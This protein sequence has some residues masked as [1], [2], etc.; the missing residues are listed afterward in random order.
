MSR[1]FLF[2]PR[3]LIL[4]LSFRGREHDCIFWC[5]VSNLVS[6]VRCVTFILIYF[7]RGFWIL[8]LQVEV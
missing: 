7:D 6:A 1:I 5:R 2:F 3:L 8:A 4:G